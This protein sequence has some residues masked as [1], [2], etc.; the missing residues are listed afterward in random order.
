MEYRLRALRISREVGNLLKAQVR[1]QSR[2]GWRVRSGGIPPIRRFLRGGGDQWRGGWL[3]SKGGGGERSR[4]LVLQL[5]ENG[6]LQGV[7][8][9]EGMS[10][11]A[12]RLRLGGRL[13]PLKKFLTQIPWRVGIE[14]GNG[15]A[16]ASISQTRGNPE[17][18][19]QD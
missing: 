17:G 15:L 14:Q 9:E 8:A 11:T 19:R 16:V 13:S 6:A 4:F 3:G 10:K 12:C 18:V 7:P 1:T 5:R 2:Q